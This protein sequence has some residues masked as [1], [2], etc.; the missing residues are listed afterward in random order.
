MSN[1][2][3]ALWSDYDE[4]H[5]SAGNKL[6]HAVG[7][8]LIVAGLLGLLAAVRL[9]EAGGWPVEAAALLLLLALPVYLWLDLRLGTA[10]IIG[11][12]LLYLIARLL[13][14]WLNLGLLVVGWIFQFVGHGVY[15]KRSPA[16]FTNLAHLLVGPL[17]VLNHLLRVRPQTARPAN[18]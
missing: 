1:R 13:P 3:E 15:E 11:S 16:F 2:F 12:A 6:C 5:R 18:R 17:W 4:H 14:W 9:A 7:I 8:P 10:M